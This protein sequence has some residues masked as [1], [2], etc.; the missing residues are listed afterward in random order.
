M[1]RHSWTVRC[2]SWLRR[3]FRRRH[4]WLG[5]WISRRNCSRRRRRRSRRRCCWC[6]N[7]SRSGCGYRRIYSNCGLGCWN[8]C[9]L[10]LL[11]ARTSRCLDYLA[12]DGITPCTANI[13]EAYPEEGPS[14]TCE[15]SIIVC[16]KVGRDLDGLGGISV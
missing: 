2:S 14:I 4:C 3:W 10:R 12:D 15:R 6:G 8:R 13:M 1:C 7:H 16:F 11:G 9:E 5:C